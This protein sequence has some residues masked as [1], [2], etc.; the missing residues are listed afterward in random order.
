MSLTIWR[1]IKAKHRS[2]AFSGLGARS[3][4]GRWNSPG[5]AMVYLAESRA[6]AALELLVHLMA[7]DLPSRYVFIPVE[8][9]DIL[10]EPLDAKRLLKDWRATPAPTRLREMGDAWLAGGS[11]AVL[12]VPSAVVPREFNF[13]LNPAHADSAKLVIGDSEPFDFDLRLAKSKG[14]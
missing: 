5:V 11:S 9:P 10:V 14:A 3:F 4:G 1:I 8:V 2:T 12:Q 7:A 13:L 6:L